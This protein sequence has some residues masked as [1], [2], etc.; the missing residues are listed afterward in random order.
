[1]VRP[2]RSLHG[3]LLTGAAIICCACTDE[4]SKGPAT[5]SPPEVPAQVTAAWLA[6]HLPLGWFN[7]VN[8]DFA[9]Y[10][11]NATAAAISECMLNEGFT[12]R[13][14]TL[15]AATIPIRSFGLLPDEDWTYGGAFGPA[16]E[17]A[18]LA[19][20]VIDAGP[21]AS[22][23][24]QTAYD[25]ALHGAD[26]RLNEVTSEVG[27]VIGTVIVSDGCVSEA[28]SRVFGGSEEFVAA[29]SLYLDLQVAVLDLQA[30][31]ESASDVV[32]ADNRWKGCMEA[33]GFMFSGPMD[34]FEYDWSS[35]PLNLDER[36]VAA[37]DRECKLQV[38]W[39]RSRFDAQYREEA[40][41]VE[42]RGDDF[43]ELRAIA[44][45]LASS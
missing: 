20:I 43:N 8:F 39:I 10:S 23:A 3:W 36:E 6:G 45:R 24:A 25:L 11:Q 21:D 9:R 18:D 7:Q 19:G 33:Q 2:R 40:A 29:T 32:A 30:R 26:A 13:G 27:S 42:A 28:Q 1:M 16:S 14:P 37:Q 12:Y 22:D 34:G 35:N 41:L 15:G 5:A 4:Q 44:V 31:V 38:D 17:P